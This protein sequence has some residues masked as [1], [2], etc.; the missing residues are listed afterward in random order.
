MFQ[1]PTNTETPRKSLR[2]IFND[3][4]AE[5]AKVLIGRPLAKAFNKLRHL[6]KS[7]IRAVFNKIANLKRADV[8]HA[9]KKSWVITKETAHD[10]TNLRDIPGTLREIGLLLTLTFL[11]YPG[12]PI[13]YFIYRV[14]KHR[15]KQAAANDNKQAATQHPAPEISAENAVPPP[16]APAAPSVTPPAMTPSANDTVQ[17]RPFDRP[18]MPSP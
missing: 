16:G 18:A 2:Q 11:P 8:K 14:G 1:K 12:L 3:K 4:V 15:L 6:K 9:L 10:L 7:D 13:S 17:K 5:P